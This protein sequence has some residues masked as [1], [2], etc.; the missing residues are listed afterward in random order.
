MLIS[1]PIILIIIQKK[2]FLL[3]FSSLTELLRQRMVLS[4]QRFVYTAEMAKRI[5]EEINFEFA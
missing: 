4:G 2:H 1:S 3:Q 5:Q